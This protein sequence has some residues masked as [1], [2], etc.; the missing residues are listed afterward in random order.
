L[1]EQR[2]V[3]LG[4][5]SRLSLNTET[6]VHVEFSSTQRSVGVDDGEA[7]FEV[8]KAAS[9]PFIVRA[10]GSEVVALGT[11]FSVRLS[12]P[13]AELGDSLAVT[14]VEGRVIVRAAA[15]AAHG[16]AP[17]QPISLVAGDRVRLTQTGRRRREGGRPAH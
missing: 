10:G 2:V 1:G 13:I 3:T 8:A 4:N 7:L 11:V 5:G 12:R 17:A 15:P 14:L 9:R 16:L 6:Q